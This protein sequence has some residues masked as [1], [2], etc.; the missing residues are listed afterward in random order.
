MREYFSAIESYQA[1]FG[2]AL[3][4][5]QKA[6]SLDTTNSYSNWCVGLC[7]LWL[8]DWPNALHHV[9]VSE[10][11]AKRAGR[12]IRPQYLSGYA[13][14]MNGHDEEASYHFK[15]AIG[16]RQQEIEY[17]APYAQQYYSQF[18]LANLYLTLGD[19]NKALEYI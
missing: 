17:T 9:A 12:K 4:Y 1:D 5:A 18:Y 2:A 7:C 11:I 6:R 8:N 13:Y 19:E 3:N 10:D 15:G 16:Q 14:H